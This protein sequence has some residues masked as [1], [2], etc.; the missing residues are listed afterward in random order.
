MKYSRLSL[1]VI[2]CTLILIMTTVP[3]YPSTRN[4]GRIRG[5]SSRQND[6]IYN[7]IAI[8]LVNGK[9]NSIS[10]DNMSSLLKNY[11]IVQFDQALNSS[12]R[13]MVL[14][15]IAYRMI[16]SYYLPRVDDKIKVY[17]QE[18]ELTRNAMP[19]TRYTSMYSPTEHAHEASLVL[20][21][22]YARVSKNRSI[23]TLRWP[24]IS[25]QV[26][27]AI[28][29]LWINRV[30]GLV[31]NAIN[32]RE[33]KDLIE[34]LNQLKLIHDNEVIYNIVLI[35]DML[36][37]NIL[38]EAIEFVFQLWQIKGIV[39]EKNL[40]PLAALL[41]QYI[42]LNSSES[43]DKLARDIRGFDD[44]HS[45][46][47]GLLQRIYSVS[48]DIKQNNPSDYAVLAMLQAV[49]NDI[50]DRV[51]MLSSEPNPSYSNFKARN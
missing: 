8:D 47:N 48:Q 3:A 43:L 46:H 30:Q 12:V 32:H 29:N 36:K 51:S 31:G 34:V 37:G 15:E 5:A 18:A 24:E 27:F 21:I 50:S 28:E 9:T 7:K 14:K 44:I 1:L 11:G 42:I 22:D 38:Y 23:G 41:R 45:L 49:L 35:P 19:G 25:S 4:F 33:S 17:K 20:P 13:N 26:S 39:S 16:R 2:S 10:I 6:R 40:P